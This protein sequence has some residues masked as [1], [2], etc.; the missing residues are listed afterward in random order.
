[1]DALNFLSI[2]Q[3][4]KLGISVELK[5]LLFL[6]LSVLVAYLSYR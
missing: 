6:L 5:L 1:M 3:L 4:N 2:L